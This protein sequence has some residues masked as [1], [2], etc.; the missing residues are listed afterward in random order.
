[1]R[2][3]V[4]LKAENIQELRDILGFIFSQ[5]CQHYLHDVKQE[6]DKE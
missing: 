5:E 1:M 4:T 6:S 3:L 2:Y